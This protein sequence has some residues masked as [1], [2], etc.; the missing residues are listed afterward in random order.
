MCVCM[1]MCM[2]MCTRACECTVSSTC[3]FI[4]VLEEAKFFGISKAIDPL[5]ALVRVG[6]DTLLVFS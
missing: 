5:E 3:M 1:C 4:G 6:S 2:C